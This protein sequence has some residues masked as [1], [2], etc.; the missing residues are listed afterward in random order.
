VCILNVIIYKTLRISIWAHKNIDLFIYWAK[1]SICLLGKNIDFFLKNDWGKIGRKIDFS[2]KNRFF[3]N[4]I[5]KSRVFVFI[6][7]RKKEN[8]KKG[9]ECVQHR[10]VCGHT[11]Y[12]K[13]RD[14]ENGMHW[15][16]SH[17]KK[18]FNRHTRHMIITYYYLKQ[19]KYILIR[20][21]QNTS[22]IST[23]IMLRVRGENFLCVILV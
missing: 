21:Y 5:K 19:N 14:H 9:Y 11:V 10:Q 6:M 16:T 12:C 8:W 13:N 1:I 4:T 7:R 23:V 15:Y 20:E 22:R 2:H 17:T 18:T 3:Y